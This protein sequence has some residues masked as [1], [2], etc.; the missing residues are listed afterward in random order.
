MFEWKLKVW[1]NGGCYE[2]GDHWTEK[3]CEAQRDLHEEITSPQLSTVTFER[4]Q[5]K[6][7]RFYSWFKGTFVILDIFWL[8]RTLTVWRWWND[9][10]EKKNKLKRTEDKKKKKKVRRRKKGIERSTWAKKKRKKSML[11]EKKTKKGCWS[12]RRRRRRQ[13]GRKRWKKNRK[14]KKRHKRKRRKTNDK[15]RSRVGAT[16]EMGFQ[17][18]DEKK[19]L[20]AKTKQ[21]TLGGGRWRYRYKRGEDEKSC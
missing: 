1:T 16:Y 2:D 14:N 13:T 18:K 8:M 17:G 10:E 21:I 11:K 3:W 7:Q 6:T 12:K 19:N 9:G 4:K 20:E 5:S 15:E